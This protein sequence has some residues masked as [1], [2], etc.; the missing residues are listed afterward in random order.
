MLFVALTQSARLL[1]MQRPQWSKDY[2]QRVMQDEVAHFLFHNFMF[3]SAAPF[4]RTFADSPIFWV[5]IHA[6]RW[7]PFQPACGLVSLFGPMLLFRRVE[8]AVSPAV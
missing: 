1:R 8:P 3:L 2:A 5:E 6:C 4:F 7:L